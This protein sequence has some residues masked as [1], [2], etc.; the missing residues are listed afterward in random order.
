MAEKKEPKNAPK[1][2]KP[3]QLVANEPKE[4]ANIDATKQE[5]S[6]NINIWKNVEEGAEILLVCKGKFNVVLKK[7]TDGKKIIGVEKGVV[8]AVLIFDGKK[9]RL[10]STCRTN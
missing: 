9:Y 6:V 10:A 7:G 4:R 1:K 2:A 5:Q 8:H 3:I